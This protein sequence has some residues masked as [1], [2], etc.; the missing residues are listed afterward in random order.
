MM[1]C[2][3]RVKKCKIHLGVGYYELLVQKYFS[4]AASL[5]KSRCMNVGMWAEAGRWVMAEYVQG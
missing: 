5:T 1:L 2:S 4:C 3:M